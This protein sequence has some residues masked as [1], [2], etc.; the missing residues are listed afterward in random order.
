MR[1]LFKFASR[2]RPEN[3]KHSLTQHLKHLSNK[4]EYKFVFTFDNDDPTMKND[5][6]SNFIKGLNIYHEIFYGDNKNKIEAYNANLENQDFDV[7]VL[8]QDDMLPCLEN[9]DEVIREIME[10]NPNALDTTIHFNTVRWVDLL[11]VWCVMGKKYYDRFNY[12][13]HPDYKSIACDNEYTEVA[14]MLGRSI[15]T[16]ICPFFHNSII[17]DTSLKNWY[18]NSEDDQT[19]HRRKAINFEINLQS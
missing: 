13:Y 3:F 8:L 11:D 6:I 19:Y 1:F 15:F 17:D 14:K 12:I 16:E 2:G 4:N 10:T 9:Y 18:F 7:L 5:E